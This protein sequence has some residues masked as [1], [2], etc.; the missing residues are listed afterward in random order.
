[1]PCEI[2]H[3]KILSSSWVVDKRILLEDM[4]TFSSSLACNSYHPQ[5]SLLSFQHIGVTISHHN[6]GQNNPTL[7]LQKNLSMV[8]FP[9]LWY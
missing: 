3:G 7:E 1:M 9:K 4:Q 6:I 2:V 5:V 8:N